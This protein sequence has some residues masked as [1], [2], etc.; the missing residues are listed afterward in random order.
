M[1]GWLVGTVLGARMAP[2]EGLAQGAVPPDVTLR[3]GRLV[4]WIGG[5]LA[6]MRAP[7]AAVTLGRTIVVRPGVRLTPALL[8]HELTHVRQ[9]RSDPLFP[10]RYAAATLRHGYRENPYEVEAREVEASPH[11]PQS[12]EDTL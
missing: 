8:A 4:P 2:P 12:G 3:Q 7:A 11:P 10:V 9:W 6:G 5:V 1:I